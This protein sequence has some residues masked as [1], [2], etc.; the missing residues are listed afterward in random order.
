MLHNELSKLDFDVAALYE[1]QLES[2]IKKFDNFALFNSGLESKKH[3]FGH[4]FYVSGEFSKYVKD[5]K[6]MNEKICCLRLKV[7]WFLCTLINVHAPT[8]EKNGRH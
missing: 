5:F 2:C 7:K 6:M 8:K 4:S 1:T 3:E